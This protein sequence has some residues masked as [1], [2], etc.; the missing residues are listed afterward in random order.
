MCTKTFY[1]YLFFSLLINNHYKNKICYSLHKV[2][3]RWDTIMHCR[4]GHSRA[5]LLKER[6]SHRSPSTA[7]Q[8]LTVQIFQQINSIISKKIIAHTLFWYPMN[9]NLF[10]YKNIY[11]YL[12]LEL[13]SD[14]HQTPPSCIIAAKFPS[15][16]LFFFF[17]QLGSFYKNLKL[18]I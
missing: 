10:I 11:I 8:T 3:Y 16:R 18:E 1:Y 4:R 15:F 5:T 2:Y 13:M 12:D 6:H 9:Q 7:D 14:K 17:L